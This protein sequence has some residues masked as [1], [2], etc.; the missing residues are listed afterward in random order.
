MDRNEP[1]RFIFSHSALREGWDNPNVFQICTLN[2][3]KSEMRK[4]QEIGRGLRLPVDET[5]CRLFDPGLNRLTVI[6]NE[7]YQEFASEL[8]KQIEE[9]T[10]EKFKDRIA[11][12]RQRRVLNLLPGWRENADFV[13]LWER[14]RYRT[15][16]S[17]DYDTSALIAKAAEYLR[18][19]PEVHAPVIHTEKRA[20]E[21][22][23]QGLASKLLVSKEEKA[24]YA[25]QALPDLLGY[26]QRE[27]RLTRSALAQILARSGR[28][29][30]ARRNPQQFLDVAARAIKQARHEMMVDGIK[31]ERIEGADGLWDM[32]LFEQ[33]EIAGYAERMVDTARSVYDAVECDSGTERKF[34]EGLESREDIKFFLKLPRWFEIETPLGKYRPDWAIVKQSAPDEPKLYLVRETKS[35]SEQFAI[36][37]SEEAKITCGKAHFRILPGVD[38]AKATDASQV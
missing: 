27:T 38:F 35:T 2:E 34:A 28:L 15:R 5:G 37:P 22:S 30:D 3:T 12:A 9:D 19:S 6:A 26:L 32:R 36:R 31:Y 14:I 23:E 29:A 4:R 8:Q 1:L 11:N 20:I 18:K 25:P 10:G 13:A 24:A 21:M 33:N 16:Y 17:V 7:S